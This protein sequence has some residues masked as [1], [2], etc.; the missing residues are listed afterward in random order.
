MTHRLFFYRYTL[1]LGCGKLSK[2]FS[3]FF[4]Y[5]DVYLGFYYERPLF[6]FFYLNS[7]GFYRKGIC[8]VL[9]RFIIEMGGI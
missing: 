2:V 9:I 6:E 5:F 7:V 8:K 1:D 3:R 4:F